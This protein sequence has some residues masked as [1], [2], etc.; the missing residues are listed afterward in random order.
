MTIGDELMSLQS[1]LSLSE[2]SLLTIACPSLRRGLVRQPAF[3]G[4]YSVR[5]KTG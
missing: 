3:F 4:W 1:T 2:G 5:S